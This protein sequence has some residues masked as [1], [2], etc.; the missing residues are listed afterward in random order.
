L[1]PEIRQMVDEGKIAFRPAVEL[2]FL[3]PEQQHALHSQMACD[4]ATPSLA[5]AQKMKQFS[6]SGKLDEN[7]ILSILSEEKPNQREYIKIPQD[8]RIFFGDTKRGPLQ[9]NGPLVISHFTCMTMP[10]LPEGSGC[11]V[12]R[13]S[14]W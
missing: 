10:W 14:A 6:Q 2:S 8:K 1:E 12:A 11:F 7:V 13:R 3:T 5:Q 4:D 9:C